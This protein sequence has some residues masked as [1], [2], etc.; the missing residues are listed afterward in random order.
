RQFFPET[1]FWSELT[2]DAGGRAA[3]QVEAPDSITT[4]MCRAVALSKEKGLGIGE[5]QLRVF[6][7][8]FLQVDLPYSA[9]RGEELPAKIALY[10]YDSA[11]Q[12][13]QV[14]LEAAPWFELLDERAKT[15][16]VE[17]NNVGAAS[18]T[19]RP[20]AL[21]VQPLKIT[22]RGRQSADA[23]VKDLVVEPEGVAREVVENLVLPAGAARALDLATPPG[24]V[25]GSP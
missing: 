5:A 6:Q 12:D 21:G 25:A 22:A 20:K 8:F 2:A 1:W 16:R 14:E 9:I 17:P 13:F 11:P 24:A 7:P 15:V 23:I 19:I 4:W 18:F 3:R 10:N